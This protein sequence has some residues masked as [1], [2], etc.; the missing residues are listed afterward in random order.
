MEGMRAW[1]TDVDRRTILIGVRPVPETGDDE[2]LVRVVA[3]GLCRTDLH[4]VDGDLPVHRPGVIPGHQVVGTV[5]RTG[6]LVGELH[7]GDLV[8]IAW[9]RRNC[10]VCRWCRSGRENLCPGSTYTGGDEDGGFAEYVTVAEAFAYLL[11]PGTDPLRAAPL[12]CAGIIGYRALTRAALPDGG[13]LG[14]Y[15]FG[16]SGPITA[17]SA[18]A[19]GARLAVMT[20]G[21]DNRDLARTLGAEFVG[22]EA[23]RR[24]RV[25]APRPHP[26]D[27]PGG[28]RLPAQLGGRGAARPA[29]GRVSGSAVIEVISTRGE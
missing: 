25:P 26:L 8:G 17:Q 18:L 1:S 19:R 12:L 3:C 4:V 11:P 14:I 21:E 7:V 9:L 27:Q 22:G 10:G 2:V 23:A 15:E 6:A 16:P 13:L 5:E 29:G 20:R 28:D 24:G